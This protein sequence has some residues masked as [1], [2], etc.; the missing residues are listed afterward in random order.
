MFLEIQIHK[1][2]N[3][4]KYEIAIT[5]LLNVDISESLE[6]SLT[7]FEISITDY[8]ALI[9]LYIYTI[10]FEPYF[11]RARACRTDQP[12]LS[13]MCAAAYCYENYSAHTLHG[14]RS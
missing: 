10:V 11:F 12:N 7:T 13:C 5:A 14:E 4:I 8:R 3:K 6:I 2:L 1:I 9:C